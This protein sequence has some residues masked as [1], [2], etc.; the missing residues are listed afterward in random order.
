MQ[1]L[2]S[3][4]G[5]GRNAFLRQHRLRRHIRQALFVAQATS[6]SRFEPGKG[7]VSTAPAMAKLPRTSVVL[8]PPGQRCFKL[9]QWNVL[10]DGLAQVKPA[11]A[12]DV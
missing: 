8:G 4:Q 5:Q 1:G 9:M 10:A 7:Q 11:T 3:L 12:A 2:G 6:S